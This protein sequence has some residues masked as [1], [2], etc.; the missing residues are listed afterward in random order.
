MDLWRKNTILE[1]SPEIL[2]ESE[3]RNINIE[4]TEIAEEVKL[5]EGG[6]FIETPAD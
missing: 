2:S 1:E 6:C 3:H 5:K 4:V